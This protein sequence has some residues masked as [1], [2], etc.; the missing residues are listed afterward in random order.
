MQFLNKFL[1]GKMMKSFF[2]L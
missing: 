2:L 1:V